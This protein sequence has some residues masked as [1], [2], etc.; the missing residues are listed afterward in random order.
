MDNQSQQ[1]KLSS[2]QEIDLVD[3][4]AVLWRRKGVVIAISAI[5]FVGGLV[6][7]MPKNMLSKEI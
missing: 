2:P 1:N 3:L 4:M 5:V 7:F 6:L